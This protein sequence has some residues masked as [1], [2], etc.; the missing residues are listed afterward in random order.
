MM[1]IRV[2]L[3]SDELTRSSLTFEN[4]IDIFNITP[5]NYKIILNEKQPDMLFVESTWLGLDD[6]W[7][8]KIAS[9]TNRPWRSNSNLKQVVNYAKQ[10]KIPTVFWNKEDGVHF[11]RFI[12]SAKLFDHIFTVDS[13]C[14]EKYKKIVSHKTTVNTLMFSIQPKIHNFSGFNFQYNRVN[15]VGSYSRHIHSKRKLWQDMM[16]ESILKSDLGLTIIDRNSDRKSTK[17]R[18]P[19]LNNFKVLPGIPYTD[20]AKIYKDY[21]LS[22]NVNT[23]EDSPT[24]FS[25]RLIEILACGGIGVTN[26]SLSV[27]AMFKDYCH[28]VSSKDEMDQLFY[29]VSKFGLSDNDKEMARA[30]AEYI[31]KE[32]TWSHRFKEVSLVLGLK[33]NNF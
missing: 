23:I 33:N 26:P 22:L 8:F 17:Y 13:N 7:K 28:I 4:E 16:F 31:L 1:P 10:L 5:W 30:G 21:A 15:F 3:I 20:T 2:A 29:R 24:M 6:T 14:I 32:H 12:K 19:S 25:R 27:D 18:Y 9:Y 11:H